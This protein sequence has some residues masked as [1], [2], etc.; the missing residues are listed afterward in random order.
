MSS[1]HIPI[2]G[3]KLNGYVGACSKVPVLWSPPTIKP[4]P[5]PKSQKPWLPLLLILLLLLMLPRLLIMIITHLRHEREKN[6]QTKVTS[7]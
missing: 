3:S 1:L 4:N 7:T 5:N 2:F 6:V